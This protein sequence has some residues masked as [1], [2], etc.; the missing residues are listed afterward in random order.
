MPDQDRFERRLT[1]GWRKVYRLTIGGVASAQEVGAAGTA[2]VARTLRLAQG[3][4]GFNQIVDALLQAGGSGTDVD[5]GP[6][7]ATLQRLR[8]I[9]AQHPDRVTRLATRDAR[10][11]LASLDQGLQQGM[12]KELAKSLC[13]SIVDH[14]FLGKVRPALVGQRFASF[15]EAS[16]WERTLHSTMGPAL[17]GLAAQLVRNP[18]SVHFR[19]PANRQHRPSTEEILS[20][21]L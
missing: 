5:N 20:E 12:T 6:A 8:S 14:Y 11:I 21:R 15:Q 4:A 19:A 1:A 3:C 2:A 10:S 18:T 9:E 13:H 16:A 7:Q 17:E